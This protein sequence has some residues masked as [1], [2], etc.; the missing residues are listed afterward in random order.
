MRVESGRRSQVF[1]DF[2]LH[3][4][5]NEAVPIIDFHTHIF[6]PE[7]IAAR[8]DF[9]ARDR[10]FGELYTHPKARMST[11]DDLVQA[12]D[13]AG[14]DW[15]VVFGFAWTDPGLCQAG[16]DYV[17]EA[18]ARFP[19]RLFGFAQV[20]PASSA[21]QEELERCLALGLS[22]VGE[23]MPDGQGYGFE[24]KCLDDLVEQA[25]FWQVPVL[26]H[27]GEPIGH[28]Y[29]GKSRGTLEPFYELALRHPGA[30][31]VAAHWGGGLLFFELMPEVREGLRSVYYDTAASPYL[32]RDDIFNVASA[33]AADKILFGTDY[34]LLAHSPFLERVR[35]TGMPEPVLDLVLGGNAARL[36][37]IG[38]DG[39]GDPI[40]CGH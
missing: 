29:P 23:L 33:I 26:I 37:G 25:G 27:A 11:A 12:M 34:P 39:H 2:S 28:R 38:E 32:Y 36:L 15:S 24:D 22:G 5:E 14:V 8:A 9:L 10:W 13:G 20:N 35:N 19:D 21:A 18:V 40:I 31:L 16:N 17:L 30:A 7:I 6:P 4:T 3:I 1:L